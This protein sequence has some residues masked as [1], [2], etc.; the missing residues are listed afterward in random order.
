MFRIKKN[1]TVMVTSGKDKSKT[2]RVININVESSRVL[3]EGVNLVKK[4][5]RANREN[6]QGGIVTME[7]PIS[8]SNVM[9]LCKSCNRPA[10]VGFSMSKDKTKSRFCRRCKQP[11]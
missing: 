3:V 10:R 8:L 4:H 1:D 9:P 7:R 2:G 5:M 6:Q 11:I